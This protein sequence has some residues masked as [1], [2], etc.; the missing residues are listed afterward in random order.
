MEIFRYGEIDST[1]SECFRKF[2]RGQSVPFAVVAGIQ[3]QGRGQFERTWYSSDTGNL[4]I[5]FGF[6]PHQSPLEFQ[7]F[8]TIVA[9][10]I[11]VRL[12]QIWDIPFTVKYPNDIYCDGKKL[13]GILTESRIING[14]IVFAVTG[15]GL[16]VAGDLSQF[17]EELRSTATTLSACCRENISR[18]RVEGIIIATMET[19][20]LA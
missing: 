9:Q 13:C 4:Y 1:N 20:V 16:N 10:K 11:T 15:I 19:L 12:Q 18:L 14:E 2:N 3:T 5:S 6:I 7:N 17:P 8:S